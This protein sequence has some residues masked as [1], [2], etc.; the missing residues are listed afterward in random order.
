MIQRLPIDDI[1]FC[2]ARE[3][4]EIETEFFAHQGRNLHPD[5]DYGYALEVRCSFTMFLEKDKAIG[6]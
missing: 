2:N 1:H 6:I 3:Q 4:E 5:S